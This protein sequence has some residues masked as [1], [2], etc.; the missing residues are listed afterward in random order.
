MKQ[1]DVIDVRR[2]LRELSVE[3]LCAS[4]EEY[5]ASQ[6]SWEFLLSKPFG[7][8]D[9][10]PHLLIGFAVTLQGLRLAPGMRVLE[11]GAGS[12]WASRFLSQL[13]CEVIAL[14][15][16]ETALRIG[17]ELYA[18]HPL[19]GDKPTP[20]FLRFDGRR[21][22]LPDKSVDRVI[23]L[24]AFHH[25]PNTAET[26]RELGRVL[27]DG[28]I[29]GF[30][31]PGPQHSNSPESQYEMRKFK[32]V[33]NDIVIENIYREA[34]AAGFTDIKLA[35][36]NV[37]SFQLSLAEFTDFLQGGAAGARYLQATRDF[38]QNQRNFFLFKG[39]AEMLDSRRRRGL[40]ARL[41]VTLDEKIV[42]EGDALSLRATIENAGAAA[43]LPKTA[44]LGAVYLGCHLQDAQ[45]TELNHDY[46]WEPLTEGDGRTVFPQ[47]TIEVELKIPAPSA[48][49]YVLEFDLVSH[50]IGW[51][52]LY[53]SE[54]ARV[55]LEVR[56][57]E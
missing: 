31:E 29:A 54:V 34:Q 4:A 52:A 25:V 38:M 28:G 35:V 11:F 46:H 45:G 9:E 44:T 56:V 47:E 13:G 19:I 3:E 20:Q 57:K 32:V 42:R 23:C 6:R 1:E 48:G 15:A 5:F 39:A 40:A 26:L 18:R 33:E 16:S 8:V 2:L 41:R 24:D 12:A 10:T 51:F 30:S 14:D 53:G 17:R 55:N 36:F 21:I 37:P 43:W 50:G 7:S 22:D 49:R 27:V